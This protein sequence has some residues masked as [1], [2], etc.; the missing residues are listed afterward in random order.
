M[1]EINIVLKSICGVYLEKIEYIT[2]YISHYISF[3]LAEELMK[4]LHLSKNNDVI[5]EKTCVP[6]MS[7]VSDMHDLNPPIGCLFMSKVCEIT[8]LSGWQKHCM[9]KS[10][11]ATNSYYSW[12]IGGKV[13]FDVD[14]CLMNILVIDTPSD[15]Y[16]LLEDFAE[17]NSE[18]KNSRID[19]YIEENKTI[20]FCIR[21]IF[22]FLN[23]LDEEDQYVISRDIGS[24]DI[25]EINKIKREMFSEMRHNTNKLIKLNIYTEGKLK[26]PLKAK[27]DNKRFLAI[28]VKLYCYIDHLYGLLTSAINAIRREKF[29]TEIYSHIDYR[30]VSKKYNGI[31]FTEKLRKHTYKFCRPGDSQIIVYLNWLGSDTLAIW[32]WCF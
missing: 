3:R 12:I 13:F 2:L 19:L 9:E 30:K 22:S 17:P 31:Y 32:K 27:R 18:H 6:D 20:E 25:D 4:F 23:E 15:F 11:G 26:I 7:K 24:I 16:K 8:G 5:N 10:K 21:H 14:F 28:I 1:I 29:V